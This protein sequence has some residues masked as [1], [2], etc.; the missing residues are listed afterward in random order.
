MA[1]L[2][3]F[4]T[5]LLWNEVSNKSIVEKILKMLGKSEDLI[6]YV[7]DRPGHDKRYSID[8]SKIQ[9]ITGWKPKYEFDQALEESVKWYMDNPQWWQS[10]C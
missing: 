5:L 1:I 3:K 4:T 10:T 7:D 2:V 6:E 8:A 9:K